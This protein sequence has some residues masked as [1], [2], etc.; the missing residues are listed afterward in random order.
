MQKQELDT[1]RL[2]EGK[3]RELVAQMEVLCRMEHAGHLSEEN[4]SLLTACGARIQDKQL[5]ESTSELDIVTNYHVG[6]ILA[7]RQDLLDALKK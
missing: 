7:L 2:C 4:R 5:P 1:F 3:A 6:Q